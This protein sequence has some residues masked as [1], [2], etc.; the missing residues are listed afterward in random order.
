MVCLKQ[1]MKRMYGSY[2]A[3]IKEVVRPRAFEPPIPGLGILC[4]ILLSYERMGRA[5]H[6]EKKRANPQNP[7]ALDA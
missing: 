1:Y 6:T 2:F 5:L 4:S 3:Q 7:Q